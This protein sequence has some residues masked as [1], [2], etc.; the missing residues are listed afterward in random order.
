MSANG[1]STTYR[2]LPDVAMVADNVYVAY[3]DG[4]NETVGGTSCAAPLWAG[5]TAL[6]NQQASSSGRSSVGFLNPAIYNLGRSA[7]Y[8][9]TFHDTTT[10]S[11]TWSESSSQFYAVS[12]YDLCTGWGTPNGQRL[13]NAL[14]GVTNWLGV[15]PQVGFKALGPMGGAFTPA[16]QNLI[17]TNG[18]S[19]PVAWSLVSTSAWLTVS[20]SGGTL[21]AGGIVS[22]SASLSDAAADLTPGI[23]GC[24]L[25]ATNS[26][27]G[28]LVP[29]QLA[30]GQSLIQNGGFE[31]GDFSDWTFSGDS[32]IGFSIYNAVESSASGYE[33][34]YAGEYGAFLGDTKRASL[35]QSFSTVP[36]QYYW[37]S[38]WLDNP[39]SGSGQQFVANWITDS[40]ASTAVNLLNPPVF[41]WTNLQFIVRATGT[42]CTLDFEAEN[43]PGYF[44]LDDISL[45]PIPSPE[46][47]LVAPSG[48]ELELSWITSPGLVYHVQYKTNLLQA[49]WQNLNPAFTATTYGGSWVD[50]NAFGSRPSRFYR[51]GVAP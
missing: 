13:I 32:V 41:A 23:Y 11:N 40:T 5:L 1:G 44:G 51:L 10:G 50:T 20:S 6:I 18:G 24:S 16:A 49:A 9:S 30:V 25:L 3:N 17:L 35:S 45:T 7:A 21:Q 28:V 2:N 47:T 37:L 38:F 14:S 26:G 27:A 42:N 33:V 46:F 36:G 31:T 19:D 34:V 39:I 29:F 48:K 43:D 4:A 15:L 8:A 12:G 22:W